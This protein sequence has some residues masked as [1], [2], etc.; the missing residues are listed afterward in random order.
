MEYETKELAKITQ[1][2]IKQKAF[3]FKGSIKQINIQLFKVKKN[4][5]HIENQQRENNSDTK[6]FQIYLLFSIIEFGMQMKL[7][8]FQ[9]N[10][11]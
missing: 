5:N 4:T 6:K 9:K 11:M 7:M 8:T 2:S 10:I 1:P 3:F